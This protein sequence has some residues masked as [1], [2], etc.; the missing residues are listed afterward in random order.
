MLPA[1][2][3]LETEDR[4]IRRFEFRLVVQ[5]EFVTAERQA[6]LLDHFELF[7]YIGVHRRLE[8][9]VGITPQHLCV[10]HRRVR[11]GQQLLCGI[12]VARIHG[13]TDAGRY[14]QCVIGDHHRF[15]HD[16][17]Q[18]ISNLG[19]LGRIADHR[20]Q[21]KLVASQTREGVAGTLVLRHALSK[22]DQQLI[23]QPMA[24]A[25]VDR[26][27]SIQIHEHQGEMSFFA[28]GATHRLIQ[29]IAQQCT[30]GQFGQAV[31]QC[32]VGQFL[33]GLRKRRRQDRRTGFQAQIQD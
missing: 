16:R 13:D 24:I 2:E 20:Q 21:D 1:Y 18:S 31:V 3:R 4:S 14:V 11:V 8:K 32:Q 26:L 28:V 22:R 29:P 12:T 9:A 10:I 33:V 27:E 23:A 5:Q 7:V 30:I 19:G 25:I 15:A 6:Q 17:D